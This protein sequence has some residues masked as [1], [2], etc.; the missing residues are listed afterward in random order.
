MRHLP[1]ATPGRDVT[2]LLAP[3][4]VSEK[5]SFEPGSCEVSRWERPCG[6]EDD[7]EE[8]EFDHAAAFCTRVIKMEDL[9]LGKQIGLGSVGAVFKGTHI[10]S[11][12]TV[13][14]KVCTPPI[15]NPTPL[16]L[17]E[18]ERE[19]DVAIRKDL[20]EQMR[21]QNRTCQDMASEIDQLSTL[22]QHPN[23]VGFVGANIDTPHD[24]ILIIEY[25]DGGCLQDVLTAKSKNG[26]WRPPKATSYS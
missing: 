12:R 18:A 3:A 9:A 25:M 8:E 1:H 24:P 19:T 7:A 10:A 16:R 26:P 13:A 5:P 11:G 2:A 17:R 22:G 15:P 14:V 4:P 23:I 6:V 21:N 20:T